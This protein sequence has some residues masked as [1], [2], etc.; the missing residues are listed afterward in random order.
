MEGGREGR[1]HMGIGC[2]DVPGNCLWWSVRSLERGEGDGFK[3]QESGSNRNQPLLK[4]IIFLG[5]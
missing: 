5:I 2:L 4:L 3:S 1:D